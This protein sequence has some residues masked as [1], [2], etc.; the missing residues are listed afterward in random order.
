MHTHHAGLLKPEQ[1]KLP[2][3]AK[4]ACSQ[5]AVRWLPVAW[6][7]GRA[8]NTSQLFSP[9]LCSA[10]RRSTPKSRAN[11]QPLTQADLLAEA[12]RTEV[13]NIQSLKLLMAMEEVGVL[14]SCIREVEHIGGRGCRWP[15]RVADLQDG[16]VAQNVGINAAI[17]L[18]RSGCKTAATDCTPL[19]AAKCI[20]VKQ[21]F[22]VLPLKGVPKG[23][24]FEGDFDQ[25]GMRWFKNCWDSSLL[26]MS[27]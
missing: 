6:E 4:S 5:C 25:V 23:V 8:H 17:C 22:K 14:H 9:L 7:S 26:Q 27:G 24:F 2:K 12:A 10:T 1:W 18:H 16:G 19:K 21:P 13:E 11:W 20:D 3:S 15:W